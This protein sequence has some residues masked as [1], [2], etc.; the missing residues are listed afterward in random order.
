M[1]DENKI[2][3]PPEFHL[4]LPGQFGDRFV[5]LLNLLEFVLLL[6]I[7]I[8]QGTNMEGRREHNHA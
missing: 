1:N 2:C 8:R 5:L 4:L 3:H 6:S 7:V